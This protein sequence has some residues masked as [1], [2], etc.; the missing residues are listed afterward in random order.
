MD[1]HLY[2]LCIAVEPTAVVYSKIFRFCLIYKLDKNA[3]G[4]VRLKTPPGQ[5][6]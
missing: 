3:R 1:W 5:G 2:E 6:L 4:I